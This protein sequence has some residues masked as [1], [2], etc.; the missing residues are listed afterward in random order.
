MRDEKASNLAD[1]DDAVYG[2]AG[3]DDNLNGEGAATLSTAAEIITPSAPETEIPPTA[4]TTST[5]RAAS[6]KSML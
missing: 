6:M 3:N 2:G 4:W 5:V 1:G